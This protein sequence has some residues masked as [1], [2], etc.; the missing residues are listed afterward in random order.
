MQ[1]A[2]R[3][4]PVSFAGG[5]GVRTTHNITERTEMN[6]NMRRKA[7]A[8]KA[9]LSAVLTDTSALTK[10]EA[11]MLSA[12]RKLDESD[13]ELIVQMMTIHAHDNPA[14]AIV[15]GKPEFVLIHGGAA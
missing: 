14:R 6:T 8:T 3:K 2:K 12:A 5:T 11:R 7:P 15:I 9:K 1:A 13:F 10:A 4:T